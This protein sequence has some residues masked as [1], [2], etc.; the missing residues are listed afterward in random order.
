MTQNLW[1]GAGGSTVCGCHFEYLSYVV[2]NSTLSYLTIQ[3]SKTLN[4]VSLLYMKDVCIW[5]ELTCWL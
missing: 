2:S 3:I 1:V 5:K 4:D